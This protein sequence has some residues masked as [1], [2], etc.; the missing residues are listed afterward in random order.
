MAALGVDQHGV[1]GVR[2]Y[3]PF[4]PHAHV[5][6]ASYAVMRVLRLEHETL[7]AEAARGFALLGQFQPIGAAQ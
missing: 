6:G 1:Y 2:V 3:F 7:D 4:P 5:F